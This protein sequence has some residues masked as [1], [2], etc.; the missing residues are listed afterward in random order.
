M[1]NKLIIDGETVMG[2]VSSAESVICKNSEGNSSNVQTELDKINTDTQTAIANI[3]EEVNNISNLYLP[4]SKTQNGRDIWYDVATLFPRSYDNI[5]AIRIN[6]GNE[7]A[8]MITLF[9]DVWSYTY[10]GRLIVGGYT[11]SPGQNW[12]APKVVKQLNSNLTVRFA[13]DANWN[14]YI[15]IGN[16]DTNWS[17]YM[18][19]TISKIITHYQSLKMVQMDFVNSFS[20]LTITSTV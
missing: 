15:L 9:I 5:G 19:A 17:G 6:L 14:K 1:A 8:S 10:M 20:G 13:H 18:G 16:A 4:K 11:Y 12:Y 2:S 3:N 7:S